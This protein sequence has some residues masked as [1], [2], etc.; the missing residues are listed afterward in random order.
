MGNKFII[1][2]TR[3]DVTIDIGDCMAIV[4][5]IL[6]LALL[7]FNHYCEEGPCKPVVDMRNRITKPDILKNLEEV[8]TKP[9]ATV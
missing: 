7:L 9:V 4:V 5:I 2:E 3:V 6:I 8:E 1:P